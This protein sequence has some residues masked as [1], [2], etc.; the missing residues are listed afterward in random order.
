MNTKYEYKKYIA[1]K[2]NLQK[3]LKK[4]GVAIIPN[5]IDIKECDEMNKGM[6]NYLEHITKNSDSKI[7]KKDNTTWRNFSTLFPKHSML[8]QQW[9]IG[10]AQF[11]WNLRQKEKIVDIFSKL[12]NCNN[13][14]LLVSFDGASFH[15]PPEVT[16]IG[17]NRNSNWLHTDISYTRS[18]EKS[19]QSWITAN[20]VNE[21]DATLTFLEKSHLYHKDFGK[22]FNIDDKNDW[23]VLN[24]NNNDELDFYLNKGCK[25]MNIKCPAGSIV[26]WNSQTI[27]SGTEAMK[28]R[29]NINT[30]CIVYLCY[31]PRS[32]ATSKDLY[33]KLKAFKELR[34][35]S[36]YPHKAKM[37][38]IIPR[39]YGKPI[40]NITQIKPP[41]LSD[42]GKKLAGF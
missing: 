39:T 35:T 24:K 33:S 25:Q 27:H 11:I 7:L 1:N 14:D 21:G 17:W 16:G 15:L 34:T 13:E 6:W 4:Y 37:F 26:F 12:W 20:D 31:S 41:I 9:S 5:V 30:R 38:P 22:H 18:D 8:L 2:D 29:E 3:V 19:I 42:L 32:M 23:Y 40:P 28:T 36:H 10:H